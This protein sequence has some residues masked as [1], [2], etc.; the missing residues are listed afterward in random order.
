MAEVAC[1]AGTVI[2]A[3]RP[4]GNYCSVLSFARNAPFDVDNDAVEPLKSLMNARLRDRHYADH[5]C[6]PECR[7]E[8]R[9]SCSRAPGA[10][11]VVVLRTGRRNNIG[12][13][14]GDFA[15]EWPD[16]VE[17]E[18]QLI[19]IEKHASHDWR[20]SRLLRPQ[21]CVHLELP[22]ALS[23]VVTDRRWAHRG[24][25]SGALVVHDDLS[26]AR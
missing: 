21:P 16:V 5:P 6:H 10:K 9:D 24:W 2:A 13:A 15:L 4:V 22:F 20:R 1:V 3:S 14:A 7:A 25:A 23:P 12:L 18:R 17:A 26:P 11:Q 19:H 8:R